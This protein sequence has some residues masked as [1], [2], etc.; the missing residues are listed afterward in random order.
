MKKQDLKLQINILIDELSDTQEA[1][2]R[3]RILYDRLA[4]H[5]TREQPKSMIEMAESLYYTSLKPNTTYPSFK[6][7]S[8]EDQDL[9]MDRLLT[10]LN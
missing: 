4:N 8:Q 2:D 1:L 3:R 7:L 10:I 9:W 5:S 6:E